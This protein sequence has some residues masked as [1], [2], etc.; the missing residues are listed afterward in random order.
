MD[1]KD[2]IGKE[3]DLF[4]DDKLKFSA[5]IVNIDPDDGISMIDLDSGRIVYCMVDMVYQLTNKHLDNWND[6]F[7][8]TVEYFHDKNELDITEIYQTG[9]ISAEEVCPF[10]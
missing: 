7:N 2:L 4:V 8:A 1:Y 6:V 5:K 3:I 10:K 9:E